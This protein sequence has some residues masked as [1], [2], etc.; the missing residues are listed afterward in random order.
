MFTAE[1]RKKAY[2]L[3]SEDTQDFISSNEL[4]KILEEISAQ[5]SLTE[6]QDL[7]LDGEIHL[8]ALGLQTI[9]ELEKHVM[10][11]GLSKEK[12]V[13]IMKQLKEQVFE[14]LEKIK[15]ANSQTRDNFVDWR[16]SLSEIGTENNLE[17]EKLPMLQDEVSA[18]ISGEKKAQDFAEN[19]VLN[20]K[21]TG[22]VGY[23]IAKKVD[24]E[25]FSAF[26]EM[27]PVEE[28]GGPTET[29]SPKPEGKTVPAPENLP[30]AERLIEDAEG[31]SDNVIDLSAQTEPRATAI[32]AK[33]EQ[34]K[35]QEPQTTRPSTNKKE[36]PGWGTVVDRKLEHEASFGEK[37]WQNRKSDT[38]ELDTVM[39]K[40]YPEGKDPYRLPPE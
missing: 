21:L 20:L 13:E 18:V 9:P 25:I 29:D 1:Q 19:I 34:P 32:Q 3:M 22:Q 4:I 28:G 6:D 5:H 36:D 38:T 37:N 14:R 30:G 15:N 7:L 23:E 16:K 39:K 12:V 10:E 17:P 27:L 35:K 26:E 31:N 40:A 11:V 24:S 33:P 2:G 8:T